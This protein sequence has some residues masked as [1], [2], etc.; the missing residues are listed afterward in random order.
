MKKQ[1]V[2]YFSNELNDE[3]SCA[4][5]KPRKIDKNYIYDYNSKFAKLKHLFWY[6][7]V[8]FPLAYLYTKIKFS[9]KII[10]QHLLV[11]YKNCGYFIYGNHTQSIGDAFLPQM[12]NKAKDKYVIVHPNNVSMPVLGRIT[13]YLG[14]IP[15]PDDIDAYRG[16][17]K[18]IE[19]R[20]F[21]KKAIIIYPEAHIWPYYTKIRPFVDSS[22]QYPVKLNAPVFCFTNTYQKR[23]F[24]KKPRIVTY[25]DGPFMPKKE[26]SIKE[27]RIDLRNQVFNCMSER[28]LSSNIEWVRYIKKE[29]IN[30]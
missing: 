13:P 15:L 30:D 29:G 21:E 11:P 27:Q 28:A 4:K 20:F 17:T 5:I 6:K 8:A 10:N 22:F 14:A 7:I 24:S 12:I 19:K 2:I 26:L 9:H 18:I 3:F 25:I 1:R 16:F 23:K